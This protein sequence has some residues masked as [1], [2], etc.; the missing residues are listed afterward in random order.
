M[1]GSTLIDLPP[2][3]SWADIAEDRC[4][5]AADA[6]P[7]A[8][9]MAEQAADVIADRIAAE[10]AAEAAASYY[11]THQ[12]PYAVYQYSTGPVVAPI[13]A[14][15]A[16]FAAPGAEFAAPIAELATAGAAPYERLPLSVR[17]VF[18][19]PALYNL[20]CPYC[21]TF[22]NF[23]YSGPEKLAAAFCGSCLVFL[24]RAPSNACACGNP[25]HLDS[26][27]KLSGKVC[28]DCHQAAAKASRREARAK[29]SRREARDKGRRGQRQRPGRAAK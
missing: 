3:H 24:S 19:T 2:L 28:S 25:R 11:S 26:L 15:G 9:I 16:E 13:V 4:A 17:R 20:L 27:A 21:Q 18:E 12:I 14:P 10:K 1:A 23:E 29:A 7:L 5:P 8:A 6:R 22:E